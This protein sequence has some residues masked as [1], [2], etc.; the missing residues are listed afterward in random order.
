MMRT[1]SVCGGSVTK[2]T[3]VFITCTAIPFLLYSVVVL[4]MTLPGHCCDNGYNEV[5]GNFTMAEDE[6]VSV[7]WF[8][9]GYAALSVGVL[10]LVTG[11]VFLCLIYSKRENSEPQSLDSIRQQEA[12]PRQ[13]GVQHTQPGVYPHPTQPGVYPHPTQPAYPQPTQPGVDPQ[14]TQPGLYP[15]HTQEG[16]YPLTVNK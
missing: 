6:A 14:L 9:S 1:A 4:S 5:T 10:F 2:R 3:A 13:V 16:E 15:Q 7:S 11:S 12:Y 8:L